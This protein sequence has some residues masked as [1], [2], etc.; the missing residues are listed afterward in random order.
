MLSVSA[1][2]ADGRSCQVEIPYDNI[3]FD[4]PTNVSLASVGP[5][6]SAVQVDNLALTVEE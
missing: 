6:G 3:R 5:V 2:T 1:T 4:R